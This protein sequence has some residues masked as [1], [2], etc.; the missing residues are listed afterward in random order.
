MK[1]NK[2]EMKTDYKSKQ[3]QFCEKIKENQVIDKDLPRPTY[4]AKSSLQ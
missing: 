1:E 4:K 2:K 3:E